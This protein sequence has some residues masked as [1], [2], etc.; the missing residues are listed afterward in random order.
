MQC[1]SWSPSSTNN[2]LL[3]DTEDYDAEMLES[4]SYRAITNKHYIK[5]DLHHMKGWLKSK[6]PFCFFRSSH[7]E[8]KEKLRLQ[9]AKLHALLS[10]TQLASAI[11][12]FASNSS[13]GIL[14]SQQM[15]WSHNMASVVASA[16]ALMTTVCAEA[17]ESLGAGRAQVA[18]AVNS[19]LAIQTPMDMI[20]VTATTATYHCLLPGLRGAA[21]LKSRALDDPSPRIP[22]MLTAGARIRIIMLSGHKE[23]KWVTLHQKQNQ[24]ILS[25]KRKYFGA[26][27]TSKEYKLINII[28]ECFEAQDQYF[29][30]LKTNNGIIK[31]LFKDEMQLSIWIS[32]I[33]SVLTSS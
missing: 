14:D 28:R 20:A 26:L 13:S 23:D 24:L 4:S 6:S 10:L 33:S 25:L 15:N 1:S 7:Q 9:T 29:V 17:A 16:A 27:T 32:T 19:G 2:L 5:L 8:K 30:S 31:L 11:S 12:G 18:S 3:K 21:I 22:E